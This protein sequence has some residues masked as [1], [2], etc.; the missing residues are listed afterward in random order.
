VPEYYLGMEPEAPYTTGNESS[1]PKYSGR[2]DKIIALLKRHRR[3]I[4]TH[5]KINLNIDCAGLTVATLGVHFS[6]N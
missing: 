4:E 6:L 3:V 5:E 2:V 1:P